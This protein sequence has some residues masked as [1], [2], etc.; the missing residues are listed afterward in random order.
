MV[1]TGC[2]SLAK[3]KLTRKS[4][5]KCR[6]MISQ[7]LVPGHGPGAVHCDNNLSA[8]INP[9]HLAKY[10]KGRVDPIIE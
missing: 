5:Y 6:A 3:L 2:L 8:G 4:I 7:I 9:D 10:T 1:F